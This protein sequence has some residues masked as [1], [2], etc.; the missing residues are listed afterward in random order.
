[1]NSDGPRVAAGALE[2]QIEPAGG[3]S[4]R[5]HSN[6]PAMTLSHRKLCVGLVAALA[7]AATGCLPLNAEVAPP[8]GTARDAGTS[9]TTGPAGPEVAA[10]VD[11]PPAVLEDAP[12]EPPPPTVDAGLEAPT[13][14]KDTGTAT[15]VASDAP[16]VVPPPEAVV[17]ASSLEKKMLFGYQGWFLC[18]GDG[19]AVN[20]WEHWFRNDTPSAANLTVDLWPDT[21]ELGADELFATQLMNADGT[22]AKLYS[23]Y[24][25]KTVARHFAWMKQNGVDGV[26]LQRF[27][28]EVQDPRFFA[29][30][31]QVAQN[32]QAGAEANGRVFALEYDITSVDEAHLI[33]WLETDWKYVVDTLKVTASPRYLH[34][35]GKPVL[36]LWGLGFS[37]RPATAADA[38]TIIDWFT[39]N[40]DP[41]YR[42]TL[43]GGIPSNW[44][45]LDGDS[46]TDAAWAPVYRSLDVLSPW[47]V[48]RYV[49][50]A[51]VDSY[52]ASTLAPDLA[53]AKAAGKRYMPVV[54]PGFSWHN[55]NAATGAVSN[56]IPRR[57]GQFYW[58]QAWN[59]VDAGVTMMKTAM[60]DEV[61]E[62]TAMFK[63]APT[64]AAAPKGATFVTLDADGTT[65]PSDFYLRVG[66]AATQMLRGT[67]P[68][69]A[70]LPVSP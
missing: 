67:V 60:F 5:L 15:E 64:Q 61:D 65:L 8:G 37:D 46:Q 52:R 57:A 40:A 48:G 20:A 70:T 33:A 32:V 35:G 18:A 63:L 31:N 4:I 54:F 28:S 38:Q 3:A 29:V 34:D 66:G 22:T 14:A 43:V 56:Q 7:T 49:D 45:T 26:A 68:T 51:G 44:R 17:D 30:R 13:A 59:A 50:D 12:V 11:G 23:A 9:D 1:M 41:Q 55:L 47:N 2:P 58:R 27:L 24:N 21:S 10:A 39:K 25:A 69:T 19:S 6:E 16:V 36:Y 62:G 42:V 53:A